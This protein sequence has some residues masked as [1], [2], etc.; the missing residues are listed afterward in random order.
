ML[1]NTQVVRVLR[2]QPNGWEIHAVWIACDGSDTR[3]SY[4][5]QR[6]PVEHRV[7]HAGGAPEHTEAEGNL[8]AAVN[9]VPVG[10]EIIIPDGYRDIVLTRANHGWISVYR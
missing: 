10:G 2:N 5:G 8:A 6:L 7:S 3:P 4:N 1:T 9:A